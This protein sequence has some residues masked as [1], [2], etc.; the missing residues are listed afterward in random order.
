[1][2]LITDHRA[3]VW[4]HHNSLM[5]RTNV[6]AT[7]QAR[8]STPREHPQSQDVRKIAISILSTVT[9]TGQLLE[10]LL[11]K[12]VRPLFSKQYHPNLTATGRKKLVPDAP[13][14]SRFSETIDWDDEN[15]IWRNGWTCDLL[16][17]ILTQYRGL[18]PGREKSTFESQFNLLIPPILNLIDDG[19]TG[20]KTQGCR[21][22]R[23]LCEQITRCQSDMLKRTGLSDV[24]SEA[25][26][27]NFMH[28]PTL[29][30][31]EES[32]TLLAELYPAFRALVDARF[33]IPRRIEPDHDKEGTILPLRPALNISSA[34]GGVKAT[35]P[36]TAPAKAPSTIPNTKDKD[37]RQ[38]LLDL[39]LRHGILASYSHA[40]DHV[41]ITSLL[42]HEASL[43]IS[44]MG[45]YAA[46]Y[47]QIFLPLLRNVLC[48]PFGTACVPL[49]MAA[50]ECMEV[51]VDVCW[52]RI[53]EKWWGECLRGI[54]GCWV[55]VVDEEG[56]GNEEELECVKGKLRDVSKLLEGVVGEAFESAKERLMDADETSRGL[57][58]D[59]TT[60]NNTEIQRVS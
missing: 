56:R 25:L 50:L 5:E 23:L 20:Y 14:G 47:L 45:I 1:V 16:G 4:P 9:D 58:D 19:D 40:I 34:K 43:L 51:L 41:R 3:D 7:L 44:M 49:L 42:L 17:F 15:K 11:S 59:A 48:N 18:S 33:P 53:R 39:V 46:K 2:Y 8:K 54:V 27:T 38:S 60:T 57:F 36:P 37:G 13:T 52:P 26:R 12:V 32:L 6:L 30:P 10:D 35:P 31:E 55:Q 24:F 22:L 29:T 21:L 28:L